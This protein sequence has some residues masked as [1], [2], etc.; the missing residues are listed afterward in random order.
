MKKT[1]W[2][3]LFLLVLA[4]DIAGIELQNET[5]EYTCKPLLMIV[6]AGYFLSQTNE[7]AGNLKK[8]I[9]IA[10]FFSWAGDVLLMFQPKDELFFMLGLAAFLLAHIFYIVFF[11]LI[12][13]REGIKSN[14]WLLLL[15]VTYYA[16]LISFL[17]P[18]LGKMKLPVRI[19]GI[20]ISFMFMLA[21]HMLFMKNKKPG[22]W[23]LL[24][25]FL[26]VVSDS[27]L[28]INKFYRDIPFAGV[29][30]MLTYGLAQLFI[31]EGAINYI[32]SATKR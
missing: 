21:M 3:I 17:S 27:L 29:L 20:V 6:L 30:I 19:Y 7:W 31:T 9:V 23:M 22:R 11:H 13:L 15:V 26:F 8:W 4:G 16:L 25:A 1:H 18:Y 32:R 28:A 14:L 24:G 12:R 5:I 2:I 10:L